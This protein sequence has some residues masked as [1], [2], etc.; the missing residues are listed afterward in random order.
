MHC[1]TQR[2]ST[3]NA[4]LSATAAFGL[5]VAVLS[6]VFAATPAHAQPTLALPSGA[7]PPCPSSGTPT[8]PCV[9][10]TPT[11]NPA[12]F[13]ITFQGLPGG[14]S[15]TNRTYLGW[16]ADLFGGFNANQSFVLY[17]SYAT[18][19]AGLISNWASVNWL[20]NHKPTSIVADSGQTVTDARTIRDVIQQV[21]WELLDGGPTSHYCCTIGTPDTMFRPQYQGTAGGISIV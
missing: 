19:P 5:A 4:R 9:T 10:V 13:N 11:L 3:I 15:I 6:L 16:C 18:L 20:L 17:S 14:Y 1:T 12:Y 8:S 7:V 21:I 2:N